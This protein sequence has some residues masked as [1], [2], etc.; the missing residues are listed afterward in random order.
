MA[1]TTQPDIEELLQRTK[2][3]QA[4][5][6]RLLEQQR[7]GQ[8]HL[9]ADPAVQQQAASVSGSGSGSASRR[10]RQ[11]QRQPDH[12]IADMWRDFA[13][14]DYYPRH[15]ALGDDDASEDDDEVAQARRRQRLQRRNEARTPWQWPQP[16]TVPQPFQLTPLRGP[17]QAM[18]DYAQQQLLREQQQ[19]DECKT[20]IRAQPAPPATWQPRFAAMQDRELAR[21]QRHAA[22]RRQLAATARENLIAQARRRQQEQ[23]ALVA[24]PPTFKAR[25][26][27]RHILQSDA[28]HQLL[29]TDAYR[30]ARREVI[31]R[32][33]LQQ[34]R[35]PGE[36]ERR[37]QAVA[38]GWDS[39]LKR[40]VTQADR[41]PGANS[42]RPP[43]TG[44]DRAAAQVQQED[45]PQRDR[46]KKTEPRPFQLT[47]PTPAKVKVARVLED[48]RQEEEH[49]KEQRWPF[50]APRKPPTLPTGLTPD[51]KAY[52][53]LGKAAAVANRERSG[54]TATTRAARLR[55]AHVSF[56]SRTG[57]GT[58]W[59]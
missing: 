3:A 50:Q 33:K 46:R 20:Q 23:A 31:A 48:M 5:T 18:H 41:R 6:L 7:R 43:P 38:L 11:Q 54:T 47:A 34:A 53:A 4:D 10:R 16:P 17:T 30:Q 37:L 36:M 13:V 35:A 56:C 25:P 22:T 58:R 49:G 57:A 44:S 21:R 40:M 1:V 24:Q 52:L 42:G 19:L 12:L 32:S 26:A 39:R 15:E 28:Y 55:Q 14:D 27:P 51:T 59:L 9:A 29:E 45:E 2:A 8:L